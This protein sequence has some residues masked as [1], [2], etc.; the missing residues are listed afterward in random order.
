M[1]RHHH[2]SHTLL[3][4]MSPEHLAQMHVGEIMNNPS[5]FRESD[6]RKSFTDYLVAFFKKPFKVS[7]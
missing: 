7:L 1:L 6:V 2:F 4:S 3:Y 5:E